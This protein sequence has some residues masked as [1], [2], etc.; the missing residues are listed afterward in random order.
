[1]VG[2]GPLSVVKAGLP[3]VVVRIGHCVAGPGAAGLAMVDNGEGRTVLEGLDKVLVT[4]GLFV[5]VLPLLGHDDTDE[6]YVGR[7]VV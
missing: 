2:P 4:D 5:V 3:A 7:S 1:M 6:V